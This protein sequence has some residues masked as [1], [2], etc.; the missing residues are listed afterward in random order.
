[1]C[2]QKIEAQ[3]TPPLRPADHVRGAVTAP[4]LLIEY[5]D[6]QCPQSGKAYATIKSLQA[7]LGARFCF[8]FR[9]FPQS[10]RYPQAQKAAET[11]EAA[12]AQGKFWEMHDLLFEQQQA[13]TDG[14][15]IAYADQLGLNVE[16]VLQDLTDHVHEPRI[17]ADIDSGY[18]YGVERAPT[19]FIG[20]R[21]QGSENLES[22]VL[23]MLQADVEP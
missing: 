10:L 8:V 4:Y 5:A 14:D 19:F 7:R 11:A 6:F 17:Q 22:L 20:I 21:H 18:Q 1:M 2:N 3:V 23:K 13:L 15:L 12:G 16:R 9:H